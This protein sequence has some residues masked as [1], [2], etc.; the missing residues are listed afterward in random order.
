MCWQSAKNRAGFIAWRDTQETSGRRVEVFI[1][2]IMVYRSFQ[3]KGRLALLNA[4]VDDENE[5]ITDTNIHS[6]IVRVWFEE[7]Q[8]E[9]HSPVWRGHDRHI[10]G[11]ELRYFK[12]LNEITEFI[13]S[14]LKTEQ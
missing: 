14:H 5:S 12:N 9:T 4:Y 11:G 8:S 3:Y 6:F 1:A 10:P 13:K 2:C 7:F